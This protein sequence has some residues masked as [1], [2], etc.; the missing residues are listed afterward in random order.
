MSTDLTPPASPVDRTLRRVLACFAVIAAVL[1]AVVTASLQNLNRSIA[2][3]DWVNHTHALI[4]EVD[5]LQPTLLAAEADLSRF[6]LTA[7]AHDHEACQEKFAELGERVDVATALAAGSAPE[8][9]EFAA[10]AERLARRAAR[11]SRLAN[12]KRAE[13]PAALQQALADEAGNGEHRE[14]THLIENFREHQTD[15]L[16]ARD[17]ASFQQAQT[18]RWTVLSGLGLDL[19]LL[20]GA[21]WLIRDDLAAR[22]RAARLLEQTNEQLEARVRERTAEL[23]AS[24]ARLAIQNLEER[25]AKQ[26]IEHQNRYNLLIIDSISDAV[27]VVTKVMNISRMNPAAVHLTGYEP[28]D[29][30]DRP[31]SRILWLA[32]DTLPTFDPMARTLIEGHEMRDKPAFLTTKGGKSVSVRLNIYPLRD[33]DKVVGGV[34]VLQFSPPDSP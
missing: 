18:T 32:G 12:L 30:I 4:T 28:A 10:I 21:A 7:D 14:L 11:A 31:L 5:A 2:T 33:R 8:A 3:S 23:T 1:V 6:L 20:F 16:S 34:V 13:D 19:L 27:F 22:R 25:W 24:N 15:L 9:A 29:L 17:R 26:A